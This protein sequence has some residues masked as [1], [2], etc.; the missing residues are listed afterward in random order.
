MCGF[1]VWEL[2]DKCLTLRDLGSKGVCDGW[3]GILGLSRS[4]PS[5]DGDECLILLIKY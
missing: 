1:K 5:C 2:G 4:P 3:T